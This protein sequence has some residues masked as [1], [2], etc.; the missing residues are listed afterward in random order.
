MV[1]SWLQRWT[2]LASAWLKQ[3]APLA[4]M[5]DIMSCSLLVE[6]KMGNQKP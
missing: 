6:E 3:I 2:A 5:S 1:F 4:M